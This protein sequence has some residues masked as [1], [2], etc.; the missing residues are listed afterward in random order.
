MEGKSNVSDNEGIFRVLRLITHRRHLRMMILSSSSVV[1]SGVFEFWAKLREE[2]L[3]GCTHQST[4]EDMKPS[5]F[6][7]L[8]TLCTEF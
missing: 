7:L 4:D 8:A 6:T 3:N 5:S 2:I 1:A